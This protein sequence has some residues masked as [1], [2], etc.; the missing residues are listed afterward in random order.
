M[1]VLGVEHWK[2]ST[3]IGIQLF[4]GD[5]VEFARGSETPIFGVNIENF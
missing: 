2:P 4:R 3:V 5:F 1:R